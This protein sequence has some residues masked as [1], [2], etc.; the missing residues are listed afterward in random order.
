MA[1]KAQDRTESDGSNPQRWNYGPGE[2]V[3]EAPDGTVYRLG[4]VPE[5]YRDRAKR[6]PNEVVL[7][8]NDAVPTAPSEKAG[9]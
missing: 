6:Y 7:G 9:G 2:L 8:E 5:P 4:D 1:Q 3:V